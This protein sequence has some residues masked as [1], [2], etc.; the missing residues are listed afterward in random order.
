[1]IRGTLPSASRVR[2]ASSA[3]PT[4]R[5]PVSFPSY[6]TGGVGTALTTLVD[7]TLVRVVLPPVTMRLA[8]RAN[9]WAPRPLRRLRI[10]EADAPAEVLH[11]EYV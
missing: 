8:G 6:A 9:R 5:R 7:A 3:T 1:M 10:R 4:G 2:L 11:R